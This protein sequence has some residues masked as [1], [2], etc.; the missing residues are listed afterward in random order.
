[1]ISLVCWIIIMISALK[2][3]SWYGMIFILLWEFYHLQR[4]ANYAVPAG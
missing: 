1:M 3:S 4:F 2:I